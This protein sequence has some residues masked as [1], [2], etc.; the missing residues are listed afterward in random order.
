MEII[1]LLMDIVVPP[2]VLIYMI[3]VLPPYLV[4]KCVITIIRMF[5]MEDLTGKVVLITGASSGIG[6][7]LAYEYA[8][9]GALLA[10]V[11]R[12]EK[13]LE[14]VAEKAR[15]FG[16]PGAIIVCADV[17][18][19]NDCKRFVEETVNHFGRL[20]HLVSNA[21]IV[22]GFYFEDS[23]DITNTNSLMNVNFWGSVY[24]TQFAL[25]HLKKS[26][27]KILVIGSASAWLYGPYIS[28]Y[29]ASKAAL[30]N[31][32]QTLRVELGSSVK[33]TIASPGFIDS[34][35]TQGKHIAVDGTVQVDKE[36]IE[37]MIGI[38]PVKS[39]RECARNIVNGV[40]RE[41]RCVTDPWWCC[42]LYVC[43]FFI[44]EVVEWLGR[45]LFVIVPNTTTM[46]PS[47]QNDI[48]DTN[49]IK[50]FPRLHE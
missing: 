12:R 26:K 39:V 48:F 3:V 22:S 11:A 18:K 47:G 38:I 7:H 23:T 46:D 49:R 21:G 42:Y 41:D 37:A 17:S 30:E 25:P 28:I 36:K 35:I 31:F 6:E 14:E 43:K 13:R 9:K 4:C 15:Q 27:G 33:I 44:P 5:T 20:D 10:L 40:C 24:S 50:K 1:H 34:E 29:S 2:M 8:R 45:T 32:Y 19:S 16:S